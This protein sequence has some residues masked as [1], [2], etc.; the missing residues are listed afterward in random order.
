ML[1]LM[2]AKRKRPRVPW[3]SLVMVPI[4]L[5]WGIR[6]FWSHDVLAWQSL[7]QQQNSL[8][9]TSYGID[10][11]RLGVGVFY[12]ERVAPPRDRATEREFFQTTAPGLTLISEEASHRKGDWL[13][14]IGFGVDRE[15]SE[16]PAFENFVRARIAIW[17]IAILFAIRAL[18]MILSARAKRAAPDE[19]TAQ[20]QG[21]GT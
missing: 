18:R 5:L 8:I 7:E 10:I 2:S 12:H 19:A 21:G 14:R 6:S 9:R 16:K 4:C 11:E 1:L 15:L 13:Y 3:L 17:L 20:A